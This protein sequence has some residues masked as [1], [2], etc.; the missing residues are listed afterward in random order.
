MVNT[1]ELEEFANSLESPRVFDAI[2]NAFYNSLDDTIAD[3]ARANHRFT[4]RTGDTEKSIYTEVDGDLG[5]VY[6]PVVPEANKIGIPYVVYLVNYDPFLDIAFDREIGNFR[7]Q[8]EK[9]LYEE[10]KE[11]Y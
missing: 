7:K 1:R 3:D 9:E 8:F 11:I 5:S 4:N 6:V 2:D 10:L